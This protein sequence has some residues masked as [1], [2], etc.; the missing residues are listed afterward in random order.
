MLL[1]YTSLY[2][3]ITIRLKMLGRWPMLGQCWATVYDVGPM[4]F[5]LW[6]DVSFVTGMDNWKAM[7]I[8]SYIE[9][10]SAL[11]VLFMCVSRHLGENVKLGN[12][13]I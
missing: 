4:L 1:T 3:I 6:V 10:K 8:R 9:T 11:P 7:E 5:Q 13:Y 12:S 2:K